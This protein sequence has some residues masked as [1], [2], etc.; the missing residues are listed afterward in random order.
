M[1]QSLITLSDVLSTR[2][3][4]VFT[5]A[6]YSRYEGKTLQSLR[7]R[8]DSRGTTDDGSFSRGQKV[9]RWR[10]SKPCH[11]GENRTHLT[12]RRGR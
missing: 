6:A 9:R 4:E 1:R 2:L 10:S 3:R 11:L 8:K 7:G 12:P 5:G